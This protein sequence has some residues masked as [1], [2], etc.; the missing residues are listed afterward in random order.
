[1]TIEFVLCLIVSDS[2][3]LADLVKCFHDLHDWMKLGM[4]LGIPYLSL[5][6]REVDEQG[7]DNRKMAMFHHWL[8]TGSANKET[9]LIALSKLDNRS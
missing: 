2:S 7:V 9:L 3:H 4:F 6:K 8:T 5:K 1:M